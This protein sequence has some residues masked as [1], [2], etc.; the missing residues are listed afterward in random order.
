MGS[1]SS[2]S[3]RS[4]SRNA[5]LFLNRKHGKTDKTG[6]MGVGVGVGVGVVLGGIFQIEKCR[7]FPEWKNMA[8][9]GNIVVGLCVGVGVGVGVGM[10]VGVKRRSAYKYAIAYLL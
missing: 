10:G 4:S 9:L 5:E 6:K 7:T 1:S 8:K 3:S 2:S